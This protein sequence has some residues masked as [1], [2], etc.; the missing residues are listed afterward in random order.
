MSG[1]STGYGAYGGNEVFNLNGYDNAVLLDG[2]N[3]Q[4]NVL[5]GEYDVVNLNSD[6]FAQPVTDSIDLGTSGFNTVLSGA[7]LTDSD[8]GIVGSGGPNTISLINH[9]G[10][11]SVSLAYTG[12][13]NYEWG[14]GT[15]DVVSLNGDASNNVAFTAGGYAAVSIGS[16]G[17]GFTNFTSNVALYGLNN[18]LVGGDEAFS[19]QQRFARQRQQRRATR[20]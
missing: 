4:V 17:D 10:Y 19:Q 5:G 1:N 15:D 18:S 14:L 8:V 6:G 12:N 2:A 11:T 20:R 3:D 7:A 9:G 16:A 13:P